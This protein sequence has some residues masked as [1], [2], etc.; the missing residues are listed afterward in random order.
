MTEV[1]FVKS[2]APK[3]GGITTATPQAGGVTTAAPEARDVTKVAFKASGATNGSTRSRERHD[4]SARGHE[5]I[6]LPRYR[7]RRDRHGRQH[8]RHHGFLL[9]RR[10]AAALR[11]VFDPGPLLAA[12][13][14]LRME[15]SRAITLCR[16]SIA[17]ERRGWSEVGKARLPKS[18]FSPAGI[19][20]LLPLSRRYRRPPFAD[21]GR[22][23][24]RHGFF[25][26]W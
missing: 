5:L 23:V 18:S 22:T 24:E 10:V 7:R 1:A 4:G 26:A 19:K 8:Q 20:A 15:T 6:V 11:L 16:L 14:A 25:G 17:V 2:A 3:V 13:G 9:Q 12:P 21:R